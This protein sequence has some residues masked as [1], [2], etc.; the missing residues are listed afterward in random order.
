MAAAHA[1]AGVYS[2]V[3]GL[4]ERDHRDAHCDP[5]ARSEHAEPGWQKCSGR[6]QRIA[7]ARAGAA[8]GGPHIQRAAD[9]YGGA[10]NSFS[11]I[12]DESFA[13]SACG[14]E[15]GPAATADPS[16]GG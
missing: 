2:G 14:V 6:E 13:A 10:A 9:Q 12:A 5:R 3:G 1:A 7:F 15:P 16:S 11:W 4:S 8:R